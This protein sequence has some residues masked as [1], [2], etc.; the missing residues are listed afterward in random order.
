MFG[1]KIIKSSSPETLNF[2]RTTHSLL[3]IIRNGGQQAKTLA[4]YLEMSKYE[5]RTDQRSFVLLKIF[6]RNRGT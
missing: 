4:S 6:V 1:E 2:G 5:C 3:P